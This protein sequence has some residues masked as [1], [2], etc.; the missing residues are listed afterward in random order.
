MVKGVKP[1]PTDDRSKYRFPL[2]GTSQPKVAD[3]IRHIVK[4]FGDQPEDMSVSLVREPEN[5]YDR[6]AVKVMWEGAQLG[7]VPMRICKA[8]GKTFPGADRTECPN[9]GVEATGDQTYFNTVISSMIESGVKIS[10]R[11]VWASA[12]PNQNPGIG[13]EI[14]VE[15]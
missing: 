8:C 15:D 11:V 10:A 4:T 14:L 13:I 6:N 2:T 12:R 5:P 1:Q 3:A 9:C 7:W